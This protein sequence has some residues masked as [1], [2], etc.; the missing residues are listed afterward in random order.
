MVGRTWTFSH[1]SQDCVTPLA[2]ELGWYMV[3]RV[4]GKYQIYDGG[5]V[6][7]YGKL[8]NRYHK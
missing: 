3:Y 7:N 2:V 5:V 6:E 1:P 4:Y 8:I